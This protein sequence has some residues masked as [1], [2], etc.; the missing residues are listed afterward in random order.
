MKSIVANLRVF[1]TGIMNS[2]KK[3]G[4][5]SA[6]VVSSESEV[7]KPPEKVRGMKVLDR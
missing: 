5:E 1:K 2:L 3:I 4:I 6:Q 7:F